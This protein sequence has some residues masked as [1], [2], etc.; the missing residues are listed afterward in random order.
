M[1]ILANDVTNVYTLDSGG[2]CCCRISLRGEYATRVVP[3]HF[4]IQ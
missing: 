4:C 2:E 1:P 3:L